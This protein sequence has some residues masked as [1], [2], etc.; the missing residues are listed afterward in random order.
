MNSQPELLK[1]LIKAF[2]VNALK[3]VFNLVEPKGRQADF[4]NQIVQSNSEKI[5]KDTLFRNFS[6]LKQHVYTYDCKGTFSSDWLLKHPSLYSTFDITKS[7]KIYNLL[8][9]TTFEF[10]NKTKAYTQE[11]QFYTPV[12]VVQKGTKL[13]V[14]VNIL[15]RDISTIIED[16]VVR[17]NRDVNDDVIL[18]DISKSLPLT[19]SITR[20]DLNRGI[21]KLWDDDE[22]DALNV[23]YNNARSISSENMNEQYL[24][25]AEYPEKYAVLIKTPL[26]HTTFKVLKAKNLINFFKVDPT[27][28]TFSFAVFPQNQA[29]INELIDLVLKHN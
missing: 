12:Q 14:H 22:I 27:R 28:G 25:K 20:A 15:E 26:S 21:K 4:I 1:R 23:K 19:V 10:Y 7:H 5:I 29:G 13:I 2:S 24:V 11:I 6:L 3:E 16:K 8:Y 17:T 9:L 18:E